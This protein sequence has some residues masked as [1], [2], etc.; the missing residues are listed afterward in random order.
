MLPNSEEGGGHRR[1]TVGA[2]VDRLGRGEV[3][4]GEGGGSGGRWRWWVKGIMRG[5]K[6]SRVLGFQRKKQIF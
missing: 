2:R 4:L 3:G 1:V 5:S 6:G